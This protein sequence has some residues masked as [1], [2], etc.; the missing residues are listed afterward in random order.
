MNYS[1]RGGGGGLLPYISQIAMCNLRQALPIYLIFPPFSSSPFLVCIA[2]VFCGPRALHNPVFASYGR[3]LG[4][5][6]VQRA[7]VTQKGPHL[8]SWPRAREEMPIMHQNPH[9]LRHLKCL[10]W[11]GKPKIAPPTYVFLA[12]SYSFALTSISSRDFP[13]LYDIMGGS[14]EICFSRG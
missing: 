4:Y 12:F 10:N 8:L 3:H 7:G 14:L 13:R 6:N 5:E 2:G 1:P 11:V 9:C